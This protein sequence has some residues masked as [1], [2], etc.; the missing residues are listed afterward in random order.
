MNFYCTQTWKIS[1]KLAIYNTRTR[2][3]YVFT[4]QLPNFQKYELCW[5][6]NIQQSAMQTHKSE[7]WKHQL[8]SVLWKYLHTHPFY[9]NEETIIFKNDSKCN[10]QLYVINFLWHY[11]SVFWN[12]YNTWCC[13][14]C[15]F[16]YLHDFFHIL[17]SLWQ[18]F[19]YGMNKWMNNWVSVYFCTCVCLF[20]YV[21]VYGYMKCI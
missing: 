11:N 20:V 3:K 14:L 15:I 17:L 8:K 18:I 1:N 21:C 9:Y 16:M 4:H 12:T 19:I 13:T 6:K 7:E 2:N 5:H 10:Y